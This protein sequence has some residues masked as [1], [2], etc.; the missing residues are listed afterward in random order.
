MDND[1]LNKTD[2]TGMRPSD[3]D[4]Q[5]NALMEDTRR[6]RLNGT[7]GNRQRNGH[8]LTR[9][10]LETGGCLLDYDLGGDGE[11]VA[12]RGNLKT[13][14]NIGIL[15]PGFGTDSTNFFRVDEDSDAARCRS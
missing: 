2:P 3:C 9:W 4:L 6:A 12:V 5:R 14:H 11:A 1:P 13:A 7:G 8:A 10:A 15:V